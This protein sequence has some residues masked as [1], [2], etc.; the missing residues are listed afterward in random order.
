ME[1]ISKTAL[2]EA[3]EKEIESNAILEV[4]TEHGQYYCDGLR[5]AISI[6]NQLSPTR[7]TKDK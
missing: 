2:I 6:I 4:T 7:N 3:L 1:Q 5:K